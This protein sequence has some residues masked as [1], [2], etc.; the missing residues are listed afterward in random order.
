MRLEKYLATSGIAS[1]RAAQ[2][3]IRTGRVTVNGERTLIAGTPVEPGKDLI[4][5]DGQCIE[6]TP[7]LI[8]LMLNKP[9]GYVTTRCDE[10]ARP[11]V[12]ELIHGIPES[13]YPVG[14]LDL[15]TEGLLLMTN[16]GQF[17]YQLTHPRH[18]VEKTY[19]TWV[20]GRPTR[21]ALAQ[22]HKG[23]QIEGRLT[24]RTI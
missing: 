11:T 22:L 9:T 3:Y 15:D 12:M 24:S 17:A 13:I 7:K 18:E 19:M 20:T 6:E 4:E 21:K 1:R 10:R 5:F 16:D 14:R 23:I 2:G 8:Y